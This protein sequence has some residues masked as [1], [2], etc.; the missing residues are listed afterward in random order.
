MPSLKKALKVFYDVFSQVAQNDYIKMKSSKWIQT[1]DRT[2]TTITF[3]IFARRCSVVDS[4]P[5]AIS[6][7][8]IKGL[9]GSHL[10]YPTKAINKLN[11][12]VI[13]WMRN[14]LQPKFQNYIGLHSS[15]SNT[16]PLISQHTCSLTTTPWSWLGAFQMHNK[17]V[18]VN[19]CTKK[20]DS[21]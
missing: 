5:M 4:P 19:H 10:K 15:P 21:P 13:L 1:S 7:R 16:I 17:E 14:L 8:C 18:Y 2:H 9:W 11:T 20:I 12:Q 3:Q 6:L